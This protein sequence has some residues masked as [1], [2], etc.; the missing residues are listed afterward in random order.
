VSDSAAS[1][2]FDPALVRQLATLIGG[3]QR[4]VVLIDGGSGAGK[5]T[6]AGQLAEQLGAQLVRLENVYPGWDGLE[7][8]ST[9]VSD[10]ILAPDDPGWR[11]WNWTLEAPS[12]W[13]LVDDARP[14][15]IE[16]SGSLSRRNRALA[17]FGI[18]VQLDPETRQRRALA[19]DGEFYAPHWD[20]WAAQEQRFASRERP[21]ELADAVVDAIRSVLVLNTTK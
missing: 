16:G 18:W 21:D 10:D 6:L 14:L 1:A 12:E 2:R 17:T 7:A 11:A 5:S 13:H 20:R 9:A 15:V 3:P 4:P 19:R 8:A